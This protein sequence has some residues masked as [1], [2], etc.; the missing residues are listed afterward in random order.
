MKIEESLNP[1]DEGRINNPQSIYTYCII[2]SNGIIEEPIKG[3]ET[4]QVYNIPYQDIGIVSSDLNGTVHNINQNHILV[5]E[6][7][8]EALM[9]RFVVLPMRF[10][11]VFK[12]RDDVLSMMENYYIDFKKNMGR[13]SNKVEFGIKV[14]WDNERELK[15]MGFSSILNDIAVTPGKSF[16]IDKLNK[17]RKNSAVREEADKW[18]EIMES[19]LD[20]LV[21]EKKIDILQ[22]KNLFI[23]ASYLVEKEKQG[24]FILSFER[25][26]HTQGDFKYLFSGPW[27]PYNFVNIGSGA[28]GM[29][30]KHDSK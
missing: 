19:Y 21:I 23:N 11:T 26:K 15:T 4:A 3:L 16:M 14:I 10:L 6:E 24:E 12:N 22:T 13:L 25:F 2:D 18:V 8:I 28:E 9:K 17:Y 1:M 27:P 30:G 5:H 29:V 20:G 7:V